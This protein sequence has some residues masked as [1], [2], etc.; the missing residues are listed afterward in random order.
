M[1]YVCEKCHY[2]TRVLERILQHMYKKHSLP[3]R[4]EYVSIVGSNF[5]A[6]NRR[7]KI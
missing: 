3:D 4:L 1:I 2:E 7:K 5:L 6:T